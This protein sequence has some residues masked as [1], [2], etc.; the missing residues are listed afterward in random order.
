MD[1]IWMDMSDFVVVLCVTGLKDRVYY[2]IR[3]PM[4]CYL[5]LL[6]VTGTR[7]LSSRI[8]LGVHFLLDRAT[9]GKVARHSLQSPWW[10][11]AFRHIL[12]SYYVR[13]RMLLLVRFSD[14]LLV[15]QGYLL[16]NMLFTVAAY[17]IPCQPF[18]C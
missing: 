6:R 16:A 7:A 4:H 11:E 18:Y 13:Y 8:L 3:E 14:G 5:Y 9:L 15:N 1:S 2:I 17:F 10:E 12:N